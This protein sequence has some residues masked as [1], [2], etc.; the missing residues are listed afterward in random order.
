MGKTTTALLISLAALLIGN[1]T[2]LPGGSGPTPTLSSVIETGNCTVT[3]EI[4]LRNGS[5]Y[6]AFMKEL[7]YVTAESAKWSNGYI[8]YPALANFNLEV[9]QNIAF[10]HTDYLWKGPHISGIITDPFLCFR[11]HWV[12]KCPSGVAPGGHLEGEDSLFEQQI[13]IT[14]F[15]F[16]EWQDVWQG[17]AQAGEYFVGAAR[18]NSPEEYYQLRASMSAVSPCWNMGGGG[19]LLEVTGYVDADSTRHYLAGDEQFPLDYPFGFPVS[20]PFDYTHFQ[21]AISGC[22]VPIIESVEPAVTKGEG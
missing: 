19:K 6:E 5:D 17:E 18:L 1:C 12:R 16:P 2:Y 10:P 13:R 22:S 3:G 7:S 8:A 21:I 11:A 9:P 14:K 20:Q 4:W 15:A